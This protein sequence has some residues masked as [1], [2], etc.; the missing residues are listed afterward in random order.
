MTGFLAELAA[1]ALRLVVVGI[2]VM[3]SA[4]VLPWVKEDVIPWLREKRIYTLV[5]KFVQ[6][7]EKMYEAGSL[8]GLKK[9]FVIHLLEAKG[10]YV[11]PEVDAF[12]ESAVKE[13][14][15][16][17]GDGL[18]DIFDEFIDETS[19]PFSDPETEGV[20]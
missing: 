20:E 10:I 1:I 14:D 13:L 7:A 19:L 12:I 15:M 5:C 9:D 4:V 18:D 2:G 3:A 16:A 6:A 11:T 17:I 8:V